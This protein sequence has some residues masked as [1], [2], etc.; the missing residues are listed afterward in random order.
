MKYIRPGLKLR[1]NLNSRWD[2]MKF[3]GQQG[4]WV[5]KSNKKQ[6]K[7][8][9]VPSTAPDTNFITRAI[10]LDIPKA[11]YNVWHKGL[12]HTFHLWNLWKNVLNYQVISVEASLLNLMRSM[13]AFPKVPYSVPPS[14]CF[15]LTICLVTFS[16]LQ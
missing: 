14:F 9:I 11:F 3:L 4:K 12:L 7:T 2:D 10:T 16:D 15:L 5:A 6:P 1:N 8:Y 13:H